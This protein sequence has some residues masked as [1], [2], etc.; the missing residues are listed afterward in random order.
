MIS[1]K[2]KFIFIH[3]PKCGGGSIRQ[4]LNQ[5]FGRKD[6]YP[7][8]DSIT[9]HWSISQFIEKDKKLLSY[10]KVGV[11]RNPWDRAV[12]WFYHC[13]ARHN[14]KVAFKDFVLNE[15]LFNFNDFASNKLIYNGK[16]IMD[17]VIKTEDIED[18]FSVFAKRF[19]IT[20]YNIP[21]N[22]HMTQRALNSD[23]RSFY[24]EETKNLIAK[25]FD[26]D[27]KTFGYKF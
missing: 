1:N 27:I 8:K 17:L 19:N 14:V 4:I 23:Y 15:D 5:N 20:N 24:D 22:R 18:D 12:S 6:E 11:I 13:K 21:R 7:Y 10:Y 16:N 9:H 2:E 26:W 3:T 25:R